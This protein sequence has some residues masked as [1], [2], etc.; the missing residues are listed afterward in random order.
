MSELV[1]GGCKVHVAVTASTTTH[2]K[3]CRLDTSRATSTR[4]KPSRY[5]RRAKARPARERVRERVTERES[6]EKT[7]MR[8]EVGKG[9]R[10]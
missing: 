6:V 7:R 4:L 9:M 3:P 10:E 1:T 2:L 8:K 5:S